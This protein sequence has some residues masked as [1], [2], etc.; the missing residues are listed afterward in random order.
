MTKTQNKIF[1][2]LQSFGDGAA[3]RA[4]HVRAFSSTLQPNWQLQWGR[5]GW[6]FNINLTRSSFGEWKFSRKFTVWKFCRRLPSNGV[7]F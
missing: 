6:R 2:G 7:V 3:E 1:F 4:N 5:L